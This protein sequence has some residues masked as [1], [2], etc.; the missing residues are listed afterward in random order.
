MSKQTFH[1]PTWRRKPT[2]DEAAPDIADS[3]LVPSES[4]A[5]PTRRKHGKRTYVIGGALLALAIAAAI[6]IPGAAGAGDDDGAG[7]ASTTLSRPDGDPSGQ[8]AEDNIYITTGVMDQETYRSETTGQTKAK[9]RLHRLQP[10]RAQRARRHERQ[11]LYRG[12]QH[13]HVR[14]ARRAEVLQG[15]GHPR[16]QGRAPSA[17]TPPPGA[18]RSWPSRS[19][20]IRTPT[21]RTRET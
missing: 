10:G 1:L 15:R 18:T 6:I 12:H 9:G 5:R 4:A 3:E 11:R 16:A 2:A 14:Q 17:A 8:T 13:E 19:R 20:T 7:G 21:G